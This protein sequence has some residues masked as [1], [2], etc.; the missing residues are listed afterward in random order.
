MFE[1]QHLAGSEPYL[2]ELAAAQTEVEHLHRAL[3]SR[4]VI[5]QAQGIVM[6]LLEIDATR[7]LEYL[8]R[9]SSSTNRKLVVIA[10]EIAETRKLPDTTKG[11]KRPGHP[12]S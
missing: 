10:A 7:A 8:K 3:E 12:L 1:S 4:L 11:K 5:G 6:A 2:S 9:M